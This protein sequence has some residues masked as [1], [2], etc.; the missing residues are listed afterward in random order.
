VTRISVHPS[1]AT[2]LIRRAV[3]RKLE[4]AQQLLWNI[5]G[6]LG[7]PQYRLSVAWSSPAVHHAVVYH[8][9]GKIAFAGDNGGLQE[10]SEHHSGVS[11][12]GLYHLIAVRQGPP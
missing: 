12:P 8:W 2:T 9:H 7:Q 10:P 11:V 1:T 4:Y 6:S 5:P 3:F